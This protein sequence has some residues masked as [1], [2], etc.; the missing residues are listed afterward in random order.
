M[1]FLLPVILL[2]KLQLSLE[3]KPIDKA[4]DTLK[5]ATLKGC[6]ASKEASSTQSCVPEKKKVLPC[7]SLL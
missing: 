4:I 7:S 1:T 6:S 2:N 3:G 5:M